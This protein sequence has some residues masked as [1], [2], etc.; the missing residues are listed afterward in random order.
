M[1]ATARVAEATT[2]AVDAYRF[3]DATLGLYHFVWNDFCDWYIELA[4]PLLL[5]EDEAARPRRRRRSAGPWR[6]SSISSSAP[7]SPRPSGGICSALPA[8]C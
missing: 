5:G 4:K 8:A 2:A 3:N 7:S 6:A 1:G